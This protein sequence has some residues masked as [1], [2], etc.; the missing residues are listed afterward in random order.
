[1]K[2]KSKSIDSRLNMFLLL[3][4]IIGG[5]FLISFYNLSPLLV[6]FRNSI[7]GKINEV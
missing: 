1:M 3:I 7:W 6:D 5:V 4:G 2:K